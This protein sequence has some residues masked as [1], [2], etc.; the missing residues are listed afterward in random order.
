MHVQHSVDLYKKQLTDS[1]YNVY[2]KFEH[3]DVVVWGS[4]EYGKWVARFL[5]EQLDM[6]HNIKCFCD[7]FHDDSVENEIENIPV[8]SPIK[9]TEKYPNAVY[10]IASDYYEDILSSI[11]KSDYSFI[12]TFRIDYDN[13]MLEKQLIFFSNEPDPKT[14]VGYNYTWISLYQDLKKS[15]KL[16]EFTNI[17]Y[18]MLEDEESRQILDNRFKTFISGDMTFIYKNPINRNC[19]FSDEYYSMGNDEVL[20]DCGAFDGD[21]IKDFYKYTN[22]LYQKILAFEPDKKNWHKLNKLVKENSFH[23]VEL[24]E[25]ATGSENGEV[26]FYHTGNMRAKIIEQANSNL[27]DSNAVKLVKL[28]NYIDYKATLIK[29][30]IEGAELDTLRG[31]AQTIKKY[32]PKLA[33]CIYHR[34]L[35]FYEI[36]MFLKSLVPEYRFKIRQHEPGFCETVLYAY[37]D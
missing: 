24:L 4:G 18:P 12:K 14:V 2:R 13:M 26:S 34:V 35:D 36:P 5:K 20:F 29:M 32:K 6:K 17:I 15:G 19:Y 11:A 1:L 23:D 10:I 25:A 9:A 3:S 7:S 8:Y 30:D 28:D 31:A 37:V 33:I 16:D 27:H 21:S 22:G